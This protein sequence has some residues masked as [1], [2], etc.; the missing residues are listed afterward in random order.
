MSNLHRGFQ[1]ADRAADAAPLVYWLEL[2]DAAPRGG[3]G[4]QRRDRRSLRACAD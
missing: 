4:R 2:V 1:G 3:E